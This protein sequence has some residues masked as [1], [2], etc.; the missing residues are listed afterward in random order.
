MC[1]GNSNPPDPT[2]MRQVP[3]GSLMASPWQRIGQF[4]WRR[5]P[6]LLLFLLLLPGACARIG[7]G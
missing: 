1:V 4:A 2:S 6:T 7:G 3:D 5:L